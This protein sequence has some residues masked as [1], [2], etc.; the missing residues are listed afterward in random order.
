MSRV[1]IPAQAATGPVSASVRGDRVKTE[2]R[3]SAGR[4]SMKQDLIGSQPYLLIYYVCLT[5]NGT[6]YR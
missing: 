2:V 1:R 6:S 5:I 4:A 3:T